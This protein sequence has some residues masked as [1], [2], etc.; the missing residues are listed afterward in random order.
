MSRADIRAKL[1]ATKKTPLI[2]VEID[3][4]KVGV[5]RPTVKERELLAKGSNGDAD[6]VAN[7]IIA[8]VVDL[9]DNQPLFED[10]DKEGMLSQEVGGIIDTLGPQIID[11]IKGQEDEKKPTGPSS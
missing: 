7:A 10:T 11:A 9:E 6:L 8:L 4:I 2:E 3:G 1:L 5:K